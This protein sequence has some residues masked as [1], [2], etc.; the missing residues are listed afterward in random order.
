LTSQ[1]APLSRR[2]VVRTR[3]RRRTLPWTEHGDGRPHLA[4]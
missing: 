1:H 3:Y 2:E 4:R